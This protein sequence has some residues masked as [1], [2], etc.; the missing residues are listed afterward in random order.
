MLKELG[1]LLMVAQTTMLVAMLID[2]CPMLFR[3][4]KSLEKLN[5]QSE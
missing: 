2:Q 3:G 5:I 4:A 1:Q